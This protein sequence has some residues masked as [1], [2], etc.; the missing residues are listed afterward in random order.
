MGGVEHGSP[1][2]ISSSQAADELFAMYGIRGCAVTLAVTL[3]R[4]LIVSS[5]HAA[6]VG[7][8]HICLGRMW[9]S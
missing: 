7:L 4:R 2:D 6:Q 8:K 9:V 5:L 1:L 3:A